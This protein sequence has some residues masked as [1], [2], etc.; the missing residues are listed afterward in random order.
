MNKKVLI[1]A[2]LLTIGGGYANAQLGKLI[3]KKGA[4]KI[5]TI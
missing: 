1:T 3:A 2:I 5:G 4:K